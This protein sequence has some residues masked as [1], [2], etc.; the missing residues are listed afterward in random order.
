MDA[1]A[2]FEAGEIDQLEHFRITRGYEWPN[3]ETPDCEYKACIPSALCY[4]C[5]LQFRGVDMRPE[6]P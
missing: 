2:A 6:A 5:T 4:R 3:C 1:D